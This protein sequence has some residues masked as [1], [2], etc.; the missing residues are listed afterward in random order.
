M[1]EVGFGTWQ[2]PDGKVAKQSVWNALDAGHRHIDTAAVY[3]NE[4]SVGEAI[5]TSG[6]GRRTQMRLAFNL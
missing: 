3:G 6:M 1:P 5:K 4:E 2:T